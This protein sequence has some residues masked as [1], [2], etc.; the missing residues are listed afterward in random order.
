M[1]RIVLS[2]L[3]AALFTVGCEDKPTP[4]PTPPAISAEAAKTAAP[5]AIKASAAPPPSGSAAALMGKMA[6][7]PNAVDGS[8]TTFNNVDG[9]V[10]LTVNR[11]ERGR[12]QGHPRPRQA[13]GRRLQGGV[14]VRAAQRRRA[15]R[16]H[17]RALPGGRPNTLVEAAD[18][19]GG[20]KITVK[21]KAPGEVDWL[22]REARER[23]TELGE[24]GGKDAGKGKM[25]HCPSAVQGSI[26]AVKDAKDSV[27]ITVTAKDAAAVTDIRER[28]K[29]VV[30][31]SKKDPKEVKHQSD[32]SGGGGL[33]RCPTVVKD[34]S[35]TAKDV[36]GGSELTVKPDKAE[37][38]AAL[39][40]E[41]RERAE[42][43]APGAAAPVPAPKPTGQ[44][45]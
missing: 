30:E 21:A 28:A 45:P 33:G 13:P 1:R 19:E 41:A 15:G 4:T 26:T 9:G 5:P 43:F 11:Q 37:G 8:S 18:V 36:P 44:K 40:K 22:R 35:V 42:N 23:Q 16:R 2:R 6:N 17:V 34:T 7:C 32:G 29:H 27:I 25:S 10:E 14:A 38:L 12:D 39:Q 24:P 31:A 20:S 3:M